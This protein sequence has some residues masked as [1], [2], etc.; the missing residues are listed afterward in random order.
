MCIRDRPKGVSLLGY[1][2]KSFPY[3][4][5]TSDAQMKDVVKPRLIAVPSHDSFRT[6][7]A[8]LNRKMES[9]SDKDFVNKAWG[10]GR[11]WLGAYKLWKCQPYSN[12]DGSI[13]Y[14][15][16]AR[17]VSNLTIQ[18]MQAIYEEDKRRGSTKN[19]GWVLD[20][21]ARCVL[22]RAG[23]PQ[24]APT[25]FPET[26]QVVLIEQ[27]ASPL[28]LCYQPTN[29]KQIWLSSLQRLYL[30]FRTLFSKIDKTLSRSLKL[31]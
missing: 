20:F 22:S 2:I 23:L 21:N 10:Y 14:D 4:V 5:S 31:N 7:F 3:Y 11:N 25:S 1:W 6:F 15:Y 18:I 29:K 16:P 12:P 8:E 28:H 13:Q 26:R 27:D 19:L 24:T 17:G 9:V 30:A